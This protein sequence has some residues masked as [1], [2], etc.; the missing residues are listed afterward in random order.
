MRLNG[1]RPALLPWLGHTREGQQGSH[2]QCQAAPVRVSCSFSSSPRSARSVFCRWTLG[3]RS[4]LAI[5]RVDPKRV[6]LR[7]AQLR[8]CTP[9]C[10]RM[11]RSRRPVRRLLPSRLRAPSLRSPLPR[12]SS[13]RWPGRAA[14]PAPRAGPRDESYTSPARLSFR[15]LWAVAECMVQR[16]ARRQRDGSKAGNVAFADYASE[17]LRG[18]WSRL[19]SPIAALSQAQTWIWTASSLLFLLNRISKLMPRSRL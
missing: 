13:A 18:A 14:C 7:C 5:S 4:I 17:L 12:R 3:M 15:E 9:A 8:I 1:R 10:T 2:Q 6:S 19:P 11:H 16:D